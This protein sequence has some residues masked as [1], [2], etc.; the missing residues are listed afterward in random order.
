[1]DTISSVR[2]QHP[3]V[4]TT[5]SSESHIKMINF[6]PPSP[7]SSMSSESQDVVITATTGPCSPTTPSTTRLLHNHDSEDHFCTPK[8]S[9]ADSGVLERI[10]EKLGT[11]GAACEIHALRL[12]Q[13]GEEETVKVIK[14]RFLI[15][16]QVC[17]IS[18]AVA[19][20]TPAS[21]RH[22]IDLT[23]SSLKCTD[24]FTDEEFICKIINEPYGK[25][26]RAYYEIK[27]AGEVARSSIFG[28]TLIRDIHDIVPMDKQR[29]YL[30][31]APPKTDEG[32]EGVYEDLHTYIRNKRRLCEKEAR[33]L[34]HQI[35]E[36]VRLCHRKGIILRDLKLKRFFFIDEARTKIQYES[37]EGSMILDNPSNDTLSDKIGCPLYTAPELLC[38]NPTYF[39]KP[40]DMWSLGVILYTMLVGQY[41]F[42]ERANCNLITIIR[43]C[44]VQIPISLSKPVRWLLLLL[45]CKNYNDRLR[46]EEV[47]LTPWLQEQKPYGNLYLHVD[48]N[49]DDLEMEDDDD[50]VAL[51][52][53]PTA[54]KEEEAALQQMHFE[55]D[56][57]GNNANADVPTNHHYIQD[58]QVA[59]DCDISANAAEPLNYS[60]HS[61]QTV[62][63]AMHLGGDVDVEMG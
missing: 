42:Y 47:F 20:K 49:L 9:L 12:E 3:S 25:V 8:K 61:L 41:P 23:A 31:I 5:P 16:T 13:G 63:H 62:N 53:S 44:Q 45:L 4:P 52:Q 1:M 51:T 28:H 34:F 7:A 54:E 40:A 27:G 36:T 59:D 56:C 39:G 11:P 29:T 48:T 17:H 32:A 15:S 30:I 46:A 19:A 18:P 22:L 26:Q 33:A 10:R 60:R 43:H 35:A 58:C 55:K 24:V 50:S 14:N 57:Q 2:T 21:Y 6:A 38:P 37:L